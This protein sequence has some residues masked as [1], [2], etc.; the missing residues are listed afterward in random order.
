M[1]VVLHDLHGVHA[2]HHEHADDAALIDEGHGDHEH[3][4]AAPAPVRL[5]RTATAMAILTATQPSARVGVTSAP[6]NILSH[7]AVRIDDDVGLL[8]L[9]STFLI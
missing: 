5:T 7:G 1:H 3:P 9:L 8:P 2:H 6:R 4:L